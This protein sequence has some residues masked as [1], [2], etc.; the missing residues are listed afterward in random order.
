MYLA[1]IKSCDS[2]A[3][4][5]YATLSIRLYLVTFFLSFRL[6]KITEFFHLAYRLFLTADVVVVYLFVYS[7]ILQSLFFTAWFLQL[8]INNSRHI[9][10]LIDI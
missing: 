2:P 1:K 8:I 9:R 10:T 4:S 7:F 5:L 3:S 6:M